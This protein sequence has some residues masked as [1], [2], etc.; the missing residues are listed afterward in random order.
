MPGIAICL[1][2]DP[3]VIC[4]IEKVNDKFDVYEIITKVS[5]ANYSAKFNIDFFK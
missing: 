5:L 1:N 4:K 2:P 3:G